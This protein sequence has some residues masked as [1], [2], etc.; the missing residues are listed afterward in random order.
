MLNRRTE[1]IILM[2]AK[3]ISAARWK[4]WPAFNGVVEF[5]KRLFN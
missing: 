4:I 3:R 5:G 1:I 2:S